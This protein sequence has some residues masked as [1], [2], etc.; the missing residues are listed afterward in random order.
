MWAG[1]MT[2]HYSPSGDEVMVS[3]FEPPRLA[4]FSRRGDS[5]GSVFDNLT[6]AVPVLAPG[7]Y[8]IGPFGAEV[9]R[10]VEGDMI[11]DTQASTG[12]PEDRVV[13]ERVERSRI[14]GS[15]RFHTR[16]SAGP[17]RGYADRAVSAFEAR[18]VAEIPATAR[19]GL[20]PLTEAPKV[21][22]VYVLRRSA[23]G[24]SASARLEGLLVQRGPCLRVVSEAS[25]SDYVV[26]WGAGFLVVPSDPVQ[27]LDV[28]NAR[29][30]AVG[31]SIVLGGSGGSVREVEGLRVPM[32]EECAGDVW[33]AGE[34]G[35]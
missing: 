21:G 22:G 2:V 34:I 13:I 26:V 16:R 29:A 3:G 30:V 27:V 10:V 7:T 35:S 25:N 28:L 18:F 9:M 14:W 20:V 19:P 4:L 33:V 24:V 32:P 15:V 17:W 1:R 23:T 31:D 5:D 11:T 8:P 6:V 12:H